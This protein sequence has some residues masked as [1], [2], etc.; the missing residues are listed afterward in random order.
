MRELGKELVVDDVAEGG[1][2]DAAFAALKTKA[3]VIER[4]GLQGF[5]AHSNDAEYIDDRFDRTA[6]LSAH[7]HDH[8]RVARASISSRR[9]R[10]RP[11]GLCAT[12]HE[13]DKPP[14]LGRSCKSTSRL[15]RANGLL[16]Q[17]CAYFRRSYHEIPIR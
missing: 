8:G 11:S 9:R 16:R 17:A 13:P 3:P 2:T 10:R 12:S 15:S 7:A 1:G 14:W 4:F 6:P 5:G